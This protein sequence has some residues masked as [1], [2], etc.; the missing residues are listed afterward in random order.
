MTQALF[1][2]L[3]LSFT[4]NLVIPTKEESHKEDQKLVQAGCDSSILLNDKT[5]LFGMLPLS[6]KHNLVIPT[7]EESH[8]ED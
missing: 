6:F 4:H 5:V 1:G 3:T 7:K 8:K 2:M